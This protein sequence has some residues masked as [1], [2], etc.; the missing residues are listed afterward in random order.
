MMNLGEVKLCATSIAGTAASDMIKNLSPN[1]VQVFY[2]GSI[3]P[4]MSGEGLSISVSSSIFEAKSLSGFDFT[5]WASNNPGSYRQGVEYA[6][7][8]IASKKIKL[9]A[10]TFKMADYAAAVKMVEES[11]AIVVL[12]D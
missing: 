5:S 6:A 10:K 3:I 2:N 11:G 12:K 7:A 4:A 1:A 8:L 9:K